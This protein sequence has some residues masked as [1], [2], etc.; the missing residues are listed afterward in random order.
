MTPDPTDSERIDAYIAG[1]DPEVQAILR[2]VRR[3]IQ[4]AAP[5]AVE[6]FSYRMPA[7][8]LQGPL[9][10]FAAWK[11]HIGLYP[12]VD[13]DTALE[14]AVAPFAGPKGNLQFPLDQPIPYELIA[15]IVRHRAAQNLARAQARTGRGRARDN[16]A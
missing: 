9:V 10:Y 1:F 7:F 16:R 15:R 5:E 14:A 13:G 3:T 4:D 8:R 12:P 6:A 11:Q 2:S